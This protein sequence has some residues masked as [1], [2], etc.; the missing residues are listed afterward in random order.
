M[1]RIRELKVRRLARTDLDSVVKLDAALSGRTRRAYFERR[2]AM[3]LRQPELHLQFAVEQ[4]GA[5]CG[6]ALARV[7]EGEFGA[8]STGLRLE[9]IS[10]AHDAQGRG[11]G[12]ALHEALEQEAAKHSIAEFRTTVA[13][14]DHD[15]LQFLDHLGYA[16]APSCVIECALRTGASEAP[17]TVQAEKRGDPNDWSASAGND[18]ERLA[19]DSADVSLLTAKD[20]EDVVRIDR[21]ITGR[22]RRRYMERALDE[23]LRESGVRISLAARQDRVMAG[24]IMARADLGDFGRT[25]PVAVI[26][27]I[28]VAP[29]YANQGIGHALLSQLFLNLTALRIERVETIVA[30]ANV[31]L[32]GFFYGTGFAPSE[33][34][35]FVKRLGA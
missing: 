1:E 34:L 24:Y 10:V 35:A 4:A 7:L 22:D 31:D 18:Y 20:L 2:L 21:H 14:R 30:A 6:H 5:H 32:L 19:R 11:A 17:A 29:E 12:R 23:A 26:D 16:L 33:R 25:E 13:W 15:L 27:T 9:V 8:A 28:G 3:A